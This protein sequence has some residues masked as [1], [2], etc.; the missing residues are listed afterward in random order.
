MHRNIFVLGNLKNMDK[1]I[2]A[3]R[4]LLVL[5]NFIFCHYF[6]SWSP[7]TY[8]LNHNQ[9]RLS[10][11]SLMLLEEILNEKVKVKVRNANVHRWIRC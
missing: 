10:N 9:I 7:V 2:L 1:L 3:L 4:G 6:G 8:Y 5:S 11:Y